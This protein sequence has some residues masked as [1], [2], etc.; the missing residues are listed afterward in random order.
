M[1]VGRKLTVRRIGADEH[2]P[3]SHHEDDPERTASS[4]RSP[5]H[6]KPTADY[7]GRL[8]AAE[9]AKGPLL[10]NMT[11][12]YSGRISSSTRRLGVNLPWSFSAAASAS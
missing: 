9:D 5:R 1:T 7:L 3:L 2:P 4:R 6:A 12:L 8:R 10:D 11:I